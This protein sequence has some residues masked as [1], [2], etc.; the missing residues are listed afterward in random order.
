MVRLLVQAGADLFM[1]ADGRP[2]GF[3]NL[4]VRRLLGSS[5]Q[6]CSHRFQANDSYM[7]GKSCGFSPVFHQDLSER[8]TLSTAHCRRGLRRGMDYLFDTNNAVL[9]AAAAKGL[10]GCS[11]EQAML[12][13]F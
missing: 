3:Q 2:T 9:I 8:R 5:L 1:G 7:D 13:G 11:E 12:K 10:R 6:G 4:S